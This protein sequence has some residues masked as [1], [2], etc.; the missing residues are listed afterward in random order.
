MCKLRQILEVVEGVGWLWGFTPPVLGK[1]AGC[2]M[3]ILMG[4]QLVIC[5]LWKLAFKTEEIMSSPPVSMRSNQ[6]IS[7]ACRGV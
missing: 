6:G 3:K 2:Q 7:F 5:F 4:L 1:E